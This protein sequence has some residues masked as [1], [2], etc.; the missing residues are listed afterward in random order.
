MSNACRTLR[1]AFK[2]KAELGEHFESSG[3]AKEQPFD[4]LEPFFNQQRRHSTLGQISPA[5]FERRAAA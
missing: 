5:A 1:R 2:P 4:Y 3:I